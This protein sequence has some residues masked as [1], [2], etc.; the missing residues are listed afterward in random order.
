ML[1]KKEKGRKEREGGRKTDS[2]PTSL[3]C[4]LRLE[5]TVNQ[6]AAWDSLHGLAKQVNLSLQLA[7]QWAAQ[8]VETVP[9]CEPLDPEVAGNRLSSE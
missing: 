4:E 6:K 9:V 1:R 3:S 8:G 7:A 5:E 2:T